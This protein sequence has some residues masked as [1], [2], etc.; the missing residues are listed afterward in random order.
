V[1]ESLLE[2]LERWLAANRPDY[3]AGLQPGVTDAQLDAFEARFALKLP[4]AFRALYRWRN[5]QADGNYKSL[6]M[7]RMFSPLED[8][9]DTKELM[10]GMIGSDFDRP[11]WWRRGW[12]PF[13][14]NGGG[15]HLC[16][17][18]A[19]EDGGQVGQLVAFWNR[20]ED[21]PIEYPSVEAWL[22]DLVES[23]ESGELEVL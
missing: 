22:A 16:V 11:E 13:L 7:N 4:A 8:V 6:Q 23:M 17:D 2:R 14:S 1:V 19:A 21:R 18:V 15:S 5:G 10:D 3:L 20:D 9:A 12:V